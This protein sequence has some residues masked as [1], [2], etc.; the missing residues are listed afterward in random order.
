MSIFTPQ[1][2]EARQ[3]KAAVSLDS[4]IQKDEILIVFS[5]DPVAKPGGLDQTYPFLPHPIFYWLTG[6]RRQ[7]AAIAYSKDF[8][9]TEYVNPISQAEVLWEGMHIVPVHKKV[10]SDLSQDLVQQ[11]WRAVHLLGQ[12][13][14]ET[15]VLA[16]N[17]DKEQTAKLK[18][19]LDE[20]RRV[21]DQEEIHLIRKASAIAQKGYERLRQ[22]IAPGLTERDLQIA[23]ESEIFSH[24]AHKVPYETIVGSGRNAAVLHAIPTSKVVQ[25]KD[26]ILIDGG[27]DLDDYCVDITRVFAAN[28]KWSAQQ[29]EIVDLVQR[30]QAKAIQACVPGTAWSEIH[31]QAAGVIA[32]GLKNLKI[33][34]GSVDDLLSSGAISVFFPHG[35][36]HMVG[37]RVRDVGFE[38][39]LTPRKHC[40]VSLRVD[41]KIQE[42]HLMTVEPGCYFIPSLLENEMTRAQ[43]K[44]FIA[45]DE[46]LKWINFGG[47]RIE[48]DVLITASQ[49]LNLTD[50]VLK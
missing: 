19:R 6:I 28:G 45:F 30:A 17:S 46:A 10:I 23:F 38:E 32:D 33:M 31:R 22:V 1:T 25:P 29:Q 27:A 14:A 39:N 35:V 9:W 24:G 37:L 16:K 34:K 7:G 47:V 50:N 2:I 21:K 11:K 49:P 18:Q 12:L 44:D 5:G 41:M 36:G 20:V 8:G 48:D 4:V 26:L 43:Y 13:T 3:K 40:G 42:N 15:L